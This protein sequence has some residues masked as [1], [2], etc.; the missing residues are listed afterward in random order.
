MTRVFS[1][2]LGLCGGSVLFLASTGYGDAPVDFQTEV[3]PIFEARCFK[4]H[5]DEKQKGDLRLDSPAWILRGSENGKVLT[6]G[7]ADDSPL[8]YLT[9]F[10][11][12]DPDYMPS[13]GKGLTKAEQQLLK[14]W[15]DEGAHFGEDMGGGMMAMAGAVPSPSGV[16]SKYTDDLPLPPATYEMPETMAAVV[17]KLEAMGLA[18]DTVNHDANY[19]EVSY[20]YAVKQKAYSLSL[21]EPV[22]GAVV[23][24]NFARSKVE[25]GQLAGLGKFKQVSHLDLRNTSVTDAALEAVGELEGLEYLN[26]FGTSVTDAGLAK[27]HRLKG[28]RRIYLHGTKAT[29]Q[30]IARLERA[31]PGLKVVR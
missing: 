22:A 11:P 7:D 26:L 29:P 24:L 9:T 5:S 31:I 30:G 20:T 8:Y 13:K 1:R 27:L 15:I 25:D 14:R 18:V 28:L 16:G 21:L 12:D 6:A 4:C 2:V 17:E 3:F 19:V 23:K 10:D